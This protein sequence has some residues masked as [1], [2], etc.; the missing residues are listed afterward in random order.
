METTLKTLLG[1]LR[2]RPEWQSPDPAVRAEAVRL[3]PAAELE[4]LTALAREDPDARVRRAA[5]KKLGDPE[6]L[7]TLAEGDTDAAVREEAAARLVHLAVHERDAEAGA[8]A[9]AM[10]R[11]PRHLAAVA[12]AAVTAPVREAAVGALSDPRALASV[13]REAEDPATRLLALSRIDDEATILAIALKTEHKPVATAAVERLAGAEALREVA[14]KAKSGAAVRRAWAR[15]EDVAPPPV[16]TPVTVTAGRE[17]D[18]Q[19]RRAYEQARTARER[20]EAERAQAFAARERVCESVGGAAGEGIPHAIEEA[21]ASWGALPPLGGADVDALVRRFEEAV[22]RARSRHEA[23]LAGASRQAEKEALV[24]RAEELAA[25]SDLAAARSGWAALRLR[26]AEAGV[27]AVPDL[28]ARLEAAGAALTARERAGREEQAR[29]DQDTL[30]RL[31]A[32]AEQAEALAR[33][34]EPPMR[35]VDHVMR[36]LRA[37]LEHPG[38][39][40]TRRDRQ[41]V[42]ARLESGRREL[43]ARLQQLR[44]DAEW[45]RWAN[46]SVQEELC[47]RVEAL[48]AE[49]DLEKADRELRDLDARW[50]QARE[51]PRDKAEGLR[52]RF[53]VAHDL[54][55]ARVDEFQA[56]QAAEL[57]DNLRKKLALCERAE[58]LA[59]STDWVRT[60]DELRRLQTE[61]KQIG[62]VVPA[63][64]PTVWRRFRRPADR[65]FARWHEHRAARVREWA[66]NLAKKEAL[67]A[68]AE[69]LMDST[70]WESTVAELKRLQAEWRTIGPVKKS[71]SEAVWTRFRQACDRFF[72]RYKNR[73]AHAQQA[74][75]AAREAILSELESLLPAEG[76]DTAPPEDL[77]P[78]LL[79]AQ[80]AWRQAGEL[81]AEAMAT[82]HERFAR[83]R[84][85]LVEAFPGAF[86]GTEL[87]PE[88][89]RLK[90]EKL[91]ARVEALLGELAPGAFSGAGPAED[92][93]SRLRDALAANTIGGPAAEEARWQ[94]ASA[95]VE[96]ARTAWRRLGPIPGPAHRE[97]GERFERACRRFQELRPRPARGRSTGAGRPRG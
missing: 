3:L 67:C 90:A 91:V 41:Q 57:A 52:A 17:Q 81:T 88:A 6:A 44:A 79:A 7:S 24:G 14:E 65:F 51:A 21:V 43:Y 92:L 75:L 8:R 54:V 10:L 56:R 39:L 49:T 64:A 4:V 58:G 69:A 19:E 48:V 50:K 68:Q 37:A 73:D 5:V 11:D 86:A 72:D 32:L 97:L 80:T 77:V 27:D 45:M 46:V 70:E 66:E 40:P 16:S 76:R 55:K 96:A 30:A 35:E 63:Q 22:R 31:I 83:A 89:S 61:W 85:R 34:D 23:H 53:R 78:H 29:R 87:D 59:E 42:R 47:A 36:E 12:K 28:R 71:R 1:R 95:E 9:V 82:L 93:A 84:E 74:V 62:P 94:A 38:H 15:L 26:C 33:A 20:E 60:A 18:E 13:V 25:S 2:G